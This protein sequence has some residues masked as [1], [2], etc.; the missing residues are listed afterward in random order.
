MHL[1]LFT[2]IIDYEIPPDIKVF[3]LGQKV[4]ENP[5]SI[6]LKIPLLS[7]K[8]KRYCKENDIHTSVSFLNRPCYANAMMK[9]LWGYKGHLIMCERSHQSTLLNSRSLPFRVISRIL[10]KY[11][12]KRANLVIANSYASR[13]DL[14]ENLD[15]TTPIR[16]IYNP[17]DLHAIRVQSEMPCSL[18]F[19]DGLFYFIS[20]GGFRREKNLTMLLESFF[21]IRHLPVRLIIVGGGEEEKNIRQKVMDLELESQVIFTGFDINPFKYVKRSDCFLLSSLFEGFPNVLLE[22]L[23]CGKPIISADCKSGPREMLAPLTDIATTAVS[24]Y[25]IA[26]YGI[27][28][29]VNDVTNMAAAMK[30]MYEDRDLKKQYEE[31]AYSRAENFDVD[32][33]KQYFHLAFSS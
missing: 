24:S 33:I 28:F 5:V 19:E 23:A 11:A 17:I 18:K 6:I 13:N 7:Y 31:K 27:L 8:L 20:V 12:Y 15:V 26:E 10:V 25:E 3:D 22:A 21:I 29:P 9:S 16:V 30:R 32:E 1:V 14:I 2:R 4:K